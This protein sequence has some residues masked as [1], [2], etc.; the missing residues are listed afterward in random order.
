MDQDTRQ[1]ITWIVIIALVASLVVFVA[2]RRAEVDILLH[3]A[4]SGNPAARV[5]AVGELVGRQRLAEALEDRPRWVQDR[6]IAAVM[7]I[8]DERALEQL[9]AA[10][11]VVDA[12]VIEEIDEYLISLGEA[13]VGPLALSIQDKDAAIRGAAGGPLKSIGAPSVASL[14]PLIDVYDDGVRGLVATTLGGIGEPAVDPLLHV[15]RQS[16]PMPGQGPAAFRRSKL[17]AV[18]AFKAMG[19]TALEP[20]IERLLAYEDAEVRLAAT[21]ILGAVAKPLDEEIGRAA[22]QPLLDRLSTDDAW[23]VRRRAASALGGLGDTALNN[24]V[25]Q[26]M[27]AALGD[28]RP[29]VRAAA[30]AA[31]G[32]L[33]DPAAAAPLAN[34]LQTNR[35]GATTEIAGALEKLGQPAIAPLTPAVQHQDV[36]VRLTATQA[37]ATIG[38]PDSVIPLGTALGDSDMKVR[39][40]A[41]NALRTLADVRVLD[42]LADA[43]ADS[44]AAVYYAA[45]DAL[46]YLGEPA[47]PALIARLGSDNARVAYMAEQ[48]LARVGAPAVAP[49]IVALQGSDSENVR[50]AG[51]ALGH[52]GSPAIEPTAAL[53]NNPSAPELSRSAAARALGL[54]GSRQASEPLQKAVTGAPAEVRRAA[55]RAI[56]AIGDDAATDVLVTALQD[57]NTNVRSTAMQVLIDW[58]LGG[59]DDKLVTVLNAQDPDASR[60]AAI[61]LAEHTPAASGELLRTVGAATE[62]VPGERE[63]VR[64]LLEHTV[65]DTG[66]PSRLRDMAISALRWV[67]DED[68]LDTLAPLISTGNPFAEASAK[69]IGSI[70]Q[71]IAAARAVE[72]A[73][74]EETVRSTRATSLLLSVFDGAQTDE[75]RLVAAAGLTVLGEE[76]VQPLIERLNSADPQRR[77]WLTAILGSIGKPAVDPLLDAR[78]KSQDQELRNWMATGLVLVG[79]A[80]ALDLLDHL[81]DNEQPDPEKVS[82]ARE[83]FVRLQ[84]L[85]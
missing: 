9:V 68:S 78:G 47:I 74:G 76:P 77:A 2:Y 13:A 28:E 18:A 15:M 33:G 85:L 83:L 26:P 4:T 82:A 45:R 35:R 80:R 3:R 11:T 42:A 23:A 55:L 29:E 20:V 10:K 41:A 5:A 60:R 52:I 46:A 81:P 43:L 16:E 7:M 8:G 66:A 12:P 72:S 50:W 34:L 17:A 84:A 53:L 49:L 71:R 69:A 79:D 14:M 27:I 31:L 1:Q 62:D 61:I 73:A 58:R 57:E 70:G 67:G 30:A 24:G 32:T 39:R 48:A 64:E 36:E 63:E 40:A 21:D 38:T 19:E 37:I 51:T 44:E 54:T 56:G 25:V 65:A 22:I 75:L 6:A 59:V